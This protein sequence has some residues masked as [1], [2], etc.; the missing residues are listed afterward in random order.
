MALIIMLARR[1]AHHRRLNRFFSRYFLA[2]LLVDFGHDLGV[3]LQVL[4][5]GFAPLTNFAFLVIEPGARFANYAMNHSQVE[6]IPTGRNTF[7]VHNV[8]FGL[9]EWRGN[10]VLDHLYLS[11]VADHFLAN[12]NL[13]RA[14]D[15]QAHAGV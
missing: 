9:A 2:Y 1:S 3:F 12:F 14:A 7:A 11:A 13:A 6:H 10:L 5:G 4:L 8:E 15:V